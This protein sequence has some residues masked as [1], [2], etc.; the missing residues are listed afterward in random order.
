MEQHYQWEIVILKPT[1]VFLSFLAAQA[2]DIELPELNVLQMDTT[3]Y[4]IQRQVSEEATLDEIGRHYPKMFKHE[5]AR[6]LGEDAPI[7]NEGSFLDFL[8]C[9]KFELHS[10]IVLMEPSI[11]EGHQ[12]LCIKPRSVLVKWMKSSIE[13]KDEVTSILERV[14]M[15]YL[16]ENATVVIK[17]FTEA[18]QINPFIEDHY[19]PI[20]T[21]EMSRMC[22]KTD[23]W[24][25]VDT[26][27]SFNRYFSVEVHTQL[28]HLHDGVAS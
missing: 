1:S 22:D 18:S 7:P 17:N 28:I 6:W 20:Y 16:T 2:P 10:Q 24:P 8:C 12:L 13:D 9:F 21:A 15:S 3:A 11:S 26:L 25:L 23:Q 5:I 27:Q 4:I 19:R 14:N